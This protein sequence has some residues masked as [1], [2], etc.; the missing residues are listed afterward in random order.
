MLKVR[1]IMERAA[2]S[3]DGT[4]LSAEEEAE[5]DAQLRKAVGET[6][7]E[8]MLEGFQLTERSLEDNVDRE[9][10]NGRVR[11]AP[12]EDSATKRSRTNGDSER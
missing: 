12:E 9:R 4:N 3:E 5:V 6:V 7:L 10:E 1:D 2:A 11:A 8:G